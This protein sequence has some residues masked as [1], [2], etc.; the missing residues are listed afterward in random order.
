MAIAGWASTVFAA[1]VLAAVLCRSGVE[2]ATLKTSM[3]PKGP[4]PLIMYFPDEKGKLR[5]AIMYG[6][7]VDQPRIDAE[8]DILFYVHRRNRTTQ[9]FVD[10]PVSLEASGFD[11]KANTFI[12]THGY[13]SSDSSDTI[14]DIKNMYLGMMDCNV[15]AVDWSNLSFNLL[16]P[17][18]KENT[19]TVG[20]YVAKFVDFVAR[21]AGVD[22]SALELVGHSLGAHVMG[23]AGKNVQAGK[24]GRI[25]GLDPAGPLYS[26]SDTSDR[27]AVGDAAFVQAI[28]TCA[29]LYGIDGAIADADFFPNGGNPIQPGCGADLDGVCSH[30]RSWMYFAESIGSSGFAAVRC[31]NYENFLEGSCNDKPSAPMGEPTPTSTRGTYYLNTAD[32]SPFA[33]G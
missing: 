26:L 32:S 14:Q 13:L 23:I 19:V 2:T 25:S 10:D 17:I 7:S 22:V 20:K 24:I 16:Y 15:V 18:A 6:A 30:S 5:P 33:L 21:V 29:G 11:P 27:L 1:T 9:V 12:I 28:H 8:K 31:E 4:L 3:G